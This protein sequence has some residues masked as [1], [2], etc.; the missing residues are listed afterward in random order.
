MCGDPVDFPDNN[1][2]AV[3]PFY[4]KRSY[5]SATLSHILGRQANSILFLFQCETCLEGMIAAQ[6]SSRQKVAF[7]KLSTRWRP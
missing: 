1:D 4:N 3:L 6:Q 5:Y 2:M 7:T